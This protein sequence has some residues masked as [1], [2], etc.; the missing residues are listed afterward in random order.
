[1][2]VLGS[3]Y[4]REAFKNYLAAFVRR[5]GGVPPNFSPKYCPQR[6]GGWYK[7]D[8]WDEEDFN[9]YCKVVTYVFVLVIVF[10]CLNSDAM[11]IELLK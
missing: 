6:G 10:F 3:A 7:T 8:R 2:D 5:G 11:S 1:M 4:I 9:K